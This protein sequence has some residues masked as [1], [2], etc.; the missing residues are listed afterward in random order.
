MNSRIMESMKNLF[1]RMDSKP[2]LS[3]KYALTVS[4]ILLMGLFLTSCSS[5]VKYE[6]RNNGSYSQNSSTKQTV[7]CLP[8]YTVI[9]GDTLS[10]I[11]E[12]CDVNMYSLAKQNDLGPPYSIYVRQELSMPTRTLNKTEQVKL[13]PQ[14]ATHSPS[15]KLKSKS[16]QW[17]WPMNSKLEH[18]FIRDS[19]G[20]S[21]LEIY[22]VSGQ[23]VNTVAPGKVVYAGNGI[24]NYGWMV[25]IKHDDNYM[26]I[27]A[28]NSALLVKEG[29]RVK[30]GQQIAT[31][32]A[33]GNTTRSKL[34]LEARYQGRKIDILKVLKK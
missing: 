25:V 4:C 26:S 18:H 29:A 9:Y 7:Q 3:R 28:H 21:V 1:I 2:N 23:E 22:G 19:S 10:D 32:G 16:S 5:P 30:R 20:L 24:V 34:Y 6:S 27:Y 31:L 33:T 11:A 8:Y 15:S 17:Q 13:R 14:T 12:E